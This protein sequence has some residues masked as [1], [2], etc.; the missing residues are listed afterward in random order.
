MAVRVSFTLKTDPATYESL[1]QHMLGLARPAG[2]LMHTSS[3]KDG[4]VAIVD[5]W[6]SQEDWDAFS[7]GPLAEG[8]KGAN[9][10]PP[11]D[12]VVTPLLHADLGS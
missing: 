1:H 5:V 11:D 9:V 4:Q 6:P 2:M 8:M 7:Q 12:L 3:E 10:A